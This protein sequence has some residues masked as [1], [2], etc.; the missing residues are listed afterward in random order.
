M[1][2]D[3]KLGILVAN[4]GKQD[5]LR[6]QVG[7]T[8]YLNFKIQPVEFIEKNTLSFLSINSNNIPLNENRADKEIKTNVVFVSENP[9]LK[10]R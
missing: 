1:E 7:G 2:Q 10:N 3:E 6:R 4:L 5:P 8:H 9:F